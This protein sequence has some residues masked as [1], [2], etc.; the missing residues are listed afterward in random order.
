MPAASLVT[1]FDVIKTRLQVSAR[2]GQVTYTGMMDCF[3]KILQQEGQNAFWKGTAGL[4]INFYFY[5][6]G[7]VLS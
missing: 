5:L 1:P 7:I 4:Q 3:R 2:E 6:P